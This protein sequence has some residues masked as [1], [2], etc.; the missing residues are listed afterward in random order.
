MAPFP[1]LF[2]DDVSRSDP[3]K[4][5]LIKARVK[6]TIPFFNR[7]EEIQRFRD[8]LRDRDPRIFVIQGPQSSGKSS[9]IEQIL[10]DSEDE[11]IGMN[12]K[13]TT[14]KDIVWLDGRRGD[15]SDLALFYGAL[16][17]FRPALAALEASLP[18]P[19]KPVLKEIK[20]AE[21]WR[22]FVSAQALE[23]PQGLIFRLNVQDDLRDVTAADTLSLFKKIVDTLEALKVAFGSLES[24]PPVLV[25]DEANELDNLARTVDG[26]TVLEQFFRFI[27]DSTKKRR[28]FHVI[29]AS[30]DA[31]FD[32]WLSKC[33][34]CCP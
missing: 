6:D 27:T 25:V 18:K 31:F 10:M 24:G 29:M 33:M 11:Q 23:L 26:Q 15:F 34:Q 32:N 30:S 4:A 13:A 12:S 16:A 2:S 8:M 22:T 5:S 9:F 20:P 3:H 1:R 21:W 19:L 7:K 17:T 28:L 14:R